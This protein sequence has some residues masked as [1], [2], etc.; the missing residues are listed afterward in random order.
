[1]S[2]LH[3]LAGAAAAV[4]LAAG[5]ALAQHEHGG[6]PATANLQGNDNSVWH[7]APEMHRFYDLSVSALGKKSMDFKAYEQKSF[8]IF[9]DFGASHGMSPAA[10]QDHLKLIPGQMVQIVKADPHVLDNYENFRDALFGPQ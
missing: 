8:A 9:R 2:R 7:N 4:L 5:P 1:M 3:R 10:M 6:P